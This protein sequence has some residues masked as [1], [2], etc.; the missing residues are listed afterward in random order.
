MVRNKADQLIESIQRSNKTWS[1]EQCKI[2]V[3]NLVTADVNQQLAAH[4]VTTANVLKGIYI[5]SAW[6]YLDNS[7]PPMDEDFLYANVLVAA[8]SNKSVTPQQLSKL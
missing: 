2:H 8:N 4:N 1:L 3:R 7:I 5:V 6:K